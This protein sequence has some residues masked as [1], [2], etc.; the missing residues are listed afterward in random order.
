[1][2]KKAYRSVL[3]K[4]VELSAV[5][6]RLKEG[7]LWVGM[8]IGKGAA[9]VVLRDSAGQFER[10][11][12][13]KLPGE[14]RELVSRLQTLKLDREVTVVLESTGTYGEALRQALTDGGLAV[15]RVRSQATSD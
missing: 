4:S 14:I 2:N 3:V 6:S 8:D 9:L 10:P 11:W 12:K 1:M 5:L 15:R 13:V 7:A